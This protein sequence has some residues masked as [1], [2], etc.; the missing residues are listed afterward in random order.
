MYTCPNCGK[1]TISGL[2]QF[3][4]PFDGKTCCPHCK[5][6]VKVKQ[7]FS[8]FLMPAYLFI[9][10]A[11]SLLFGIRFDLTMS[12]ELLIIAV[13]FFPAGPIDIV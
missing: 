3:S 11:L 5:A 10:P 9:R 12:S 1:L 8:N 13:V 7:Q 2:T 6:A 4:P